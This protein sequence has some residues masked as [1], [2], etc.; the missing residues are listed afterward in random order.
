MTV[1]VDTSI[2]FAFYSIR[3]RYHLDSLA[4]VAHMIEGEWGRAYVTNHILDEILTLLKYRIS[5][6]TAEVF[7]ESF[8]KE[9]LVEIIHTDERV[10]NKP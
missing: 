1:I 4:I 7:I 10:E 8:I 9:H 3:D 5:P 2:L 6:K